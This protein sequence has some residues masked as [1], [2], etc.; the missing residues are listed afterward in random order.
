MGRVKRRSPPPA[1]QDQW[2]IA[3]PWGVLGGGLPCPGRLTFDEYRAETLR[4]MEQVQEEF[5]AFVE[6]LRFA[7]DKAEFD[8]FVAECRARIAGPSRQAAD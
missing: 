4:R 5:A 7:R 8:Q 6:R 1:Q 2:V 3:P